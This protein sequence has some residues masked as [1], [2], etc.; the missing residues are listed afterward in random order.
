MAEI[1]HLSV[2]NDSLWNCA[3]RIFSVEGME[4]ETTIPDLLMSIGGVLY[5]L[6]GTSNSFIA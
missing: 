3:T 4:N 5:G 2:F 1:V 6:I